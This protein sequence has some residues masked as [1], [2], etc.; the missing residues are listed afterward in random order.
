MSQLRKLPKLTPQFSA[1]VEGRVLIFDADILAYQVTATVKRLPTAIRNFQRGIQELMFLTNSTYARVHLTASGSYKTGRHLVI[2]SKPYQVSR[3]GKG[4]PPLLEPLRE[5][6]TNPEHW[7]PQFEVTLHRV[8]EADDQCIIDSYFYK[9]NGVVNVSDKDLRQTPYPIYEHRTG[10]VIKCEGVGKLWWHTTEAGNQNLEGHGRIFFWA[11]MLMGDTADDIRGLERGYGKLFGSKSTY[12]A[13]HGLDCEHDIA[14]LV[15]DLYRSGNQNPYPEG[16]LLHMLR[17]A[18]DTI[19][20]VFDNIHWTET[21]K[22]FL[23]ECES[24]E[25]FI[26]GDV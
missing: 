19:H 18:S 14:N 23:D 2:A 7:L 25:W 1:P 20:D 3:D 11:Q 12:D 22:E 9:D 24:R 4:K 26:E 17:S 10:E 15:V 16:Y 5:A 6:M 13:L 21:N 8:L